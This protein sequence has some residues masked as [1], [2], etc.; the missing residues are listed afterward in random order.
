MSQID[1]FVPGL[2]KTNERML[3]RI[4]NAESYRFHTLVTKPEIMQGEIPIA[5][6]LRK[7]REQLDGFDGEIGAIVGYWD[8]PVTTMVPLLCH[9]HGLPSPNLT[10]VIRC[11]HK[12]WSRLEQRKVIDE[13]PRFALVDLDGDAGPPAGLRYP[14]WLKPV[15]SF[16]SELA[17]KVADDEE[18]ADAVRQIREGIHRVGRPFQYV[19]DQVEELDLPEEIAEIGALACLAEEAMSGVQAATEGFGY[20]GEV[21]VYGVLDSLNYPNRSSFLRHQYPSQ[22]PERVQRRMIDVSERV[23]PQMGLGNSTFSIEFFCDPDSG[24]VCVL[25]INARH[26]QSHAELFEHVDGVPNHH[27]MVELGLGRRPE[28]PHR[29]GRYRIAAKYYHRRFDGDAVVRR[30]PTAEEIERVR[31]EI[32]G[33][34]VD[35]VPEAGT[36]LSDMPGQDSYS[37]ELAHVFVGADSERELDE[38]Y[39]RVIAALP[40]EFDEAR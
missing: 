23:I 2:D 33:I 30:V 10:G 21:T 18:F 1:I 38:K 27:C 36:R 40:F 26:S 7:A 16:S 20:D 17:F 39:R 35:V 37:Y 34:T 19:L 5:D 6:L 14:M 31:R 22:L 3:R 8:F 11:E 13:H 12:Y 25:E 29:R 4:P 24:D 15:K 28:M 9:R 32:P